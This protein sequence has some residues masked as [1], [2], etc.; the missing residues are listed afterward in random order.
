MRVVLLAQGPPEV[1]SSRTR[2]FA[3]V[4]SLHQAGIQTDVL[5]W[6]SRDYVAQTRRGRVSARGHVR[7]LAHNLRA[8]RSLLRLAEG[9]DAVLIQKV[10]LPA[11]YL[12]LVR[13]RTRRLVFDYDD[14]LY[15]LAPGD[16]RG[17]RAVIRRRRL[18]R[19]T[20]CLAAS[21]LVVLENE[22]NRAFAERHGATTLTI[23]GP[24]DTERYRPP[25]SRP[26]DDRVVLG[27]IG[28]PS[29]TGY[30]KLVEGAVAALARAGRPIVVHLIG[31]AP[32]TVPGVSVRHVPWTLDG[33][34]D[35]L[36]TFDVGLMPLTDDPWSR[37]KGGYKI[38]QYMAMGVP[39]VASPVGINAE[40]VRDGITG[41]LATSED[42]WRRALD[43]LVADA[44]ARRRM[45]AAARVEAVTRYSLGYYAPLWVR[46]VTGTLPTAATPLDAAMR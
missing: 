41:L 10:V 11:W 1:A 46:G 42:G 20:A 36:A 35:A 45:G 17:A 3:F 15:A 16:E 23:T 2:V 34:V 12:R 13:R 37:G 18:R 31:A 27:W 7:R 9:S 26:R 8:A 44:A 24:I 39:T 33:E 38:L 22:A 32:W 40:L 25:S 5:V 29:T 43:V 4:P 19:V 6:N 14:A 21:D 30:L 28:S